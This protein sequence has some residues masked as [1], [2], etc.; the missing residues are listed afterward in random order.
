MTEHKDEIFGWFQGK[1][2]IIG[3]IVSPIFQSMNGIASPLTLATRFTINPW[4][5]SSSQVKLFNRGSS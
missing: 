4:N 2:K 3:D 1:S 5:P